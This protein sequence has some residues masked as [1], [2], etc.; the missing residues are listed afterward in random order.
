MLLTGAA[1]APQAGISAPSQEAALA[2]EA[3]A[4]ALQAATPP[5][6]WVGTFSQYD[7]REGTTETEAI[8]ECVTTHAPAS[9]LR[10]YSAILQ[11]IA[12]VGPTGKTCTVIPGAAGTLDLG[13]SCNLEGG[14]AVLKASAAGSAKPGEVEVA[15]NIGVEAAAPKVASLSST[16]RRTGDCE[17]SLKP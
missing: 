14:A 16:V 10:P 9:F 17:A 5:G 15:L 2:V 11:G 8:D 7:S 13:I 1:D 12:N 3:Y 4:Q 6:R